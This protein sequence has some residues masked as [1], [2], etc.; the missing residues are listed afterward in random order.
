MVCEGVGS[1]VICPC[2][3]VGGVII[4]GMLEGEGEGAD[5]K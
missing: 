2:P 1:L 3:E 5:R 4:K